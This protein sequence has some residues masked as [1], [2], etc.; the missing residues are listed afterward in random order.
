[1]VATTYETKVKT[2]F[3]R[4]QSPFHRGNGCYLT[5]ARITTKS[6]KTFSPLFIGAMVATW[7]GHPDSLDN[8][9]F[10]SPFHRGNGCYYLIKQYERMFAQLSVRFSSRQ[11][12]LLL[13]YISGHRVRQLSVRFSSAAMVATRKRGTPSGHVTFLFSPLF[14]AAM[15]ATLKVQGCAP[16]SFCFQ[17]AFHRG[18]GC[19][20][21]LQG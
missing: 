14:I 3:E 18:N 15:V 20:K 1:M 19:Y 13:S 21:I 9:H 5:K 16:I 10:Q 6:T 2:Y 11:W 4:F 8:V 7:K 12:L 17:S